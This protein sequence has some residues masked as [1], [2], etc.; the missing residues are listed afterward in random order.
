MKLFAEYRA[1]A[2][3]SLREN[4]HSFA[5]VTL[6][7]YA[8][9]CLS[10]TSYLIKMFGY[11]S[12][13]FLSR[14]ITFA[15]VILIASPLEFAFFILCLRN[16][17]KNQNTQSLISSWFSIFAEKYEQSVIAMF[18]IA[19]LELLLGAI[20]LGIGAIVLSM[21]YAMVPFIY[22][23]EPSLDF[24]DALRISREMMYGHKVDLLLLYLS[25]IG[26]FLV[27]IMTCGVGMLWV[28]PYV[29]T[30]VAH[31]YEDVKTEFLSRTDKAINE[32]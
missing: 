5:I 12:D 31:F 19:L 20:T 17:R 18:V 22:E 24:R 1:L 32:E 3:E 23:D 7:F 10:G 25:F 30:A 26:W 13:L 29:V 27:G 9:S 2:R 4:W 6:I 21:A 14:G 11:Y 8:I 15:F 28:Y 16:V